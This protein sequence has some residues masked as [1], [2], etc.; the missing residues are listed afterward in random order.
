VAT[1]RVDVRRSFVFRADDD[2]ANLDERVD[3]LAGRAL[4]PPALGVRVESR[5]NVLES[6]EKCGGRLLPVFISAA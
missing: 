1:E 2:G 6:P 5:G 4:M 3:G